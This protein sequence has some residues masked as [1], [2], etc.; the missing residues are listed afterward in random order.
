[1]HPKVL[2]LLVLGILALLL[3]GVGGI[4]GGYIAYLASGRKINPTIGIAGVSCVPSTAKVVQK[5]V[6]L[7]APDVIVLPE[8]LGANI[9]GVI[10]TAI[11]TG[12]YVTLVPL[13][14]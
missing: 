3:S 14:T 9:S 7:V 5:E 6:S 11:L 1:L 8:A 12:I 13:L 2:I 4:V 10:T